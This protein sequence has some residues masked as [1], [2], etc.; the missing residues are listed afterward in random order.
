MSET[1]DKPNS[2]PTCPTKEMS[3]SMHRDWTRNQDNLQRRRYAEA[4]LSGLIAKHSDSD[5][6]D[7]KDCIAIWA[8]NYADAMLIEQHRREAQGEREP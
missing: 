8:F 6:E 2:G 1:P 7:L 4:A 3:E 5:Y